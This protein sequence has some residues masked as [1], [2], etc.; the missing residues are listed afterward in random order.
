MVSL[1]WDTESDL[2]LHVQFPSGD[3]GTGEIWSRKP[4]GLPLGSGGPPMPRPPWLG[5]LDFD[6]NCECVIDG[7]GQENVFFRPPRPSGQFIA[8]VDTFSLVQPGGGG[9]ASA[10]IFGRIDQSLWR[11]AMG[12]RPHGHTLSTWPGRGS[13]SAGL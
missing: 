6:S 1:D 11:S 2:D 3:G 4:T 7:R 5:Y 12:S 13:P 8:R 10:P 9:L